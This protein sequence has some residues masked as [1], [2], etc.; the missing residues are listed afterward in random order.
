M[1]FSMIFSIFS[2]GPQLAKTF[3]SPRGGRGGH[4]ERGGGLGNALMQGQGSSEE[5]AR[6]VAPDEQQ[7]CSDK[8][9]EWWRGMCFVFGLLRAPVLAAF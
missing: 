7:A 4:V 9:V 3:P 2:R 1:G 6:A 8:C 5:G